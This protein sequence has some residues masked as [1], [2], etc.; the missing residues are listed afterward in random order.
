[1][2]FEDIRLLFDTTLNVEIPDG[3]SRGH[4]VREAAVL[5]EFLDQVNT[6]TVRS[7]Y[8]GAMHGNHPNP[9]YTIP[10]LPPRFPQFDNG[11]R[12]GGDGIVTRAEFREHYKTR[13]STLVVDDHL[14]DGRK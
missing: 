11:G 9:H 12:E 1:M 14:F 3:L 4:D 10:A 5:A 7:F 2:T 6:D 13:V 8:W